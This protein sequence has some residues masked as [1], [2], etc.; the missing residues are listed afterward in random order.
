[1]K[2]ILHKKPKQFTNIKCYV[3]SKRFKFY[4][5]IQNI[6]IGHNRWPKHVGG[7]AVYITINLHICI[8]I[9]GFVS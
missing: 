1:V 9:V 7:Y 6:D 5:K 2:D 3:L 8:C 4:I